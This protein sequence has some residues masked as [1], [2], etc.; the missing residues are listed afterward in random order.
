MTVA[1]FCS[2]VWWDRKLSILS[3]VF[4][5]WCQAVLIRLS[6]LM[7]LRSRYVRVLFSSMAVVRSRLSA[8]FMVAFAF[9]MLFLC[10][11][12]RMSST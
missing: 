6:L 7:S 10:V 4:S 9:S 3:E 1:F 11:S 8:F 2:A 12:R 5:F